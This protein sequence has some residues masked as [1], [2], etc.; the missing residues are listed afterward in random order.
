MVYL[1]WYSDVSECN[2]SS[3]RGSLTQ[4]DFLS[5]NSHAWGIALNNEASE[6][7]ASWTLRV[8]AR[9]GQDKVPIC[10]TSVGDPHLGAID[11]VVI[12]ISDGP[13]LDA[14]NI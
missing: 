6:S 3:I 14:S 12:A 9:S 4:V 13:G 8:I 10:N 2:T 7:L 5:A 1:S 11:D